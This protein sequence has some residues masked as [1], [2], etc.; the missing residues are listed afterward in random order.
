MP[1]AR[2]KK[3][4][5]PGVSLRLLLLQIALLGGVAWLAISEWAALT[6]SE[7][8]MRLLLSVL[9]FL[10]LAWAAAFG[11]TLWTYI[12]ISL[13][14]FFDLI[15]TALRG[16][17]HAVWIVPALLMVMRPATRVAV[18]IGILFIVNTARLLVANPPPQTKLSSRQ[19]LRAP[20]RLFGAACISGG[21]F[22]KETSPCLFGALVL[23]TGLFAAWAEYTQWAAVLLAAGV[24]SLTWSSV[25]R[26]SYLPRRRRHVLHTALS[27][28]MALLLTVPLMV[29]RQGA[30]APSV[31]QILSRLTA[32]PADDADPASAL[33]ATR[34]ELRQLVNPEPSK[35]AAAASPAKKKAMPVFS[36]AVE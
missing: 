31:D 6:A 9:F 3:Q 25:A 16:S 28:A 20:H 8:P 33:E 22:S 1:R 29:V 30:P 17:V 15:G 19:A 34:R 32:K 12:A 23:Q 2:R 24:A 21:L 7:S 18:A 27:V 11:M 36:P 13:D 26:G 14:D 4:K 35:P 10:L 5:G